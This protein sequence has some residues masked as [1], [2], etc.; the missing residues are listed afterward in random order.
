VDRHLLF[1]YGTLMSGDGRGSVLTG[2]DTSIGRVDL[3][4]PVA[5]GA[6]RGLMY[7]AG[8]GMF[9]AVTEGDGVVHGEV[10]EAPDEAHLRAALGITDRIEGYR[11]PGV[12]GNLYDRVELPLLSIEQQRADVPLIEP[13][14]TVLTYRWADANR[15]LANLIPSGDW[16]EYK[17][18]DT[19]YYE[20]VGA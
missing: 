15:Y 17:A 16:R 6:I 20:E 10:W 5:R 4:K 12:P 9:P 1:F 3:A 11:G 18:N 14:D 7:D 8:G 2:R 19:W 13:G